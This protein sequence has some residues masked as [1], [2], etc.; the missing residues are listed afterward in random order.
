MT[1]Y[2][3]L[4]DNATIAEMNCYD[5]TSSNSVVTFD[6]LI[7]RSSEKEDFYLLYLNAQEFTNCKNSKDPNWKIKPNT[8]IRLKIARKD[9]EKQDYKTK[10]KTTVS[11]TLV[12][13][14]LCK[15]FDALDIPFYA[16]KGT[17]NFGCPTES[18]IQFISG[19]SSS[20]ETLPDQIIRYL[21]TTFCDIQAFDASEVKM[22]AGKELS[23]TVE[24]N[25]NTSNYR[26][27]KSEGDKLQEKFDWISKQVQLKF[28][29][30]EIK[31]FYD[32]TEDGCAFQS[33]PEEVK[34]SL[35]RYVS[36]L[37]HF[38]GEQGG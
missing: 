12:E 14:A 17:I 29:A 36:E 6:E 27:P 11:P 25:N 10:E 13:Q 32:V 24:Q 15:L 21:A 16:F 26:P 30:V 35:Y 22:F 7:I 18:L 31:S 34:I 9:Y 5:Y 19:K 37:R 4:R 23:L 2:F 38:T 8:K 28:P 1:H 33:V 20:G 3:Y